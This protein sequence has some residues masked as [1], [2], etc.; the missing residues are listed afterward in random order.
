MQERVKG[1]ERFSIITRENG[2]EQ[3]RNI[4]VSEKERRTFEI[5]DKF[6]ETGRRLLSQFHDQYTGIRYINVGLKTHF[7]LVN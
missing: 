6:G 3:E 2:N 1:P 5:L 4:E 7:F